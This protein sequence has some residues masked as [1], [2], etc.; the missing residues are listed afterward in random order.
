MNVQEISGELYALR[1]RGRGKDYLK[2]ERAKFHKEFSLNLASFV[3]DFLKSD[4][5]KSLSSKE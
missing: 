4:M 2:A 1:H 5:L 3:R